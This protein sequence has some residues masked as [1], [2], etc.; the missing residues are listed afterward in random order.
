MCLA[1]ISK[2]TLMAENLLK[3]GL[4]EIREK[5][6]EFHGDACT[7]S[8]FGARMGLYAR[9][10]LGLEELKHN[11]LV[12]IAESQACMVDGIEFTTG[13]TV[14]SETLIIEDYGK[15]GAVFYNRTTGEVIRLKLEPEIDREHE[16]YGAVAA[17]FQS[18][19]KKLSK[20]EIEKG[21]EELKKKRKGIFKK[22]LHSPDEDIFVLEKVELKREPEVPLEKK[23]IVN[24]ATCD[25]CGDFVEKTKAEERDGKLFCIPCAGGAVY[26]KAR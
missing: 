24:L 18:R 2:S 13:C 3:G 11:E 15:F 23:F 25:E 1:E 19:K 4:D 22:I 14:G 10:E 5:L 6:I 20:E 17:R 21:K 16:E 8:M 26:K 7:A 9:K 12:T